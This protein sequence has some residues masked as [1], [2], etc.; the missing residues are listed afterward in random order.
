M[1]LIGLLRFRKRRVDVL[2][3]LFAAATRFSGFVISFSN[4]VKSLSAL[5]CASDS[6]FKSSSK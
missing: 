5:S 2:V 1:S 3:R 4:R 6:F